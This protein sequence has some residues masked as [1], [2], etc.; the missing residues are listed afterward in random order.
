MLLPEKTLLPLL[1]ELVFFSM[2]QVVFDQ[3]ADVN[4]M[5]R[6]KTHEND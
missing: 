3:L 6:C 1:R 4:Q 5:F 2:R